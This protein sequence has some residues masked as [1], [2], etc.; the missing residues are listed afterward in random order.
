MSVAVSDTYTGGGTVHYVAIGLPAGL[1]I[2][3]SSGTIS[4]TLAVGDG[5]ESPYTV[6]VIANDGTYSATQSFDWTVN[7][8][9]TITAPLD[10]TNN[11]GDSPSLS[12]SASGGG[13]LS[14]AALGL[15]AGLKIN[16][17]TGAITGTVAVG[18]A[19]NG[20]YSVTILVGD[21]TSSATQS[22]NWTIN[23]PITITTPDDQT[24]NDGDSV[25]L[26][27]SASGSGTLTYSVLD[28]PP[29]LSVNPSTGAISGTVALGDSGIGSFSPTIV[30]SNGTYASSTNFNWTINGAITIS[31]PGDQAN[32]VGD[33]V[34][35]QLVAADTGVGT[36]SYAAWG[37][38]AGLSLNTS[39]G[40][41]S[42][43][44]GSGGTAIGTYATTVTIS[45]G[46]NVATDTFNWTI[47]AAGTIT[48][49][50]PS[51]QTTTEGSSVRCRSVPPVAAPSTT[52][53]SDSLQG[54]SSTRAAGPSAGPLLLTTQRMDLTT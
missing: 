45:D 42:G 34:S 46:T 9:I 36:M 41:I 38:P 3:A 16:A 54:W 33:T 15:P 24:N 35:L 29:G 2:S 31:D 23:S 30:V 14:Y 7:D 18:A 52:S 37:L 10:Q 40:L 51:N 26:S 39:T 25:S 27:I 5:F 13:T 1:S 17:S 44:V 6:T 20:P 53:P 21:G 12:I 49:T 50:T 32:V 19:A 48:L 8:P 43:T 28:L 4:G 11:E 47:S 22:F